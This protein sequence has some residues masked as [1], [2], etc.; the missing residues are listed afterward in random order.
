MVKIARVVINVVIVVA[1][2]Y[3]VA[4]AMALTLVPQRPST[5]RITQEAPEFV[6]S[7][8]TR[9]APLGAYDVINRRNLFQAFDPAKVKKKPPPPP[10]EPKKK[11]ITELPLSKL[12]VRLLGTIYS[13][14]P[15]LRRAVVI[16]GNNQLLLKEKDK[17]RG[18]NILDIRRRAVRLDH[19]K[20]DELLVIDNNEDAKIAA[21]SETGRVAV[22]EEVAEK[23]RRNLQDILES[24]QMV[25]ARVDKNRGLLVKQLQP[26]T[27]LHSLGLRQNDLVLSVNDKAMDKLDNVMALRSFF[28]DDTVEVKILREGDVETLIFEFQ[29]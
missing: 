16:D 18:R 21:K 5:P 22:S 7:T 15:G 2:A 6:V 25:P 3:F 11:K 27:F 29:R 10:P 14:D 12:G 17:I 9:Q 26:N 20:T 19:G 1:S 24:I 8:E 4:S 23:S 13:N 28:D